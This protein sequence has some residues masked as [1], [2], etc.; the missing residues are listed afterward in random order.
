VPRVAVYQQNRT[1]HFTG[2][3]L[4]GATEQEMFKPS[5]FM[6]SHN[7]QVNFLFLNGRKDFINRFAVANPFYDI[8]T[9]RLFGFDDAVYFFSFFFYKFLLQIK[10]KNFAEYDQ[11]IDIGFIIG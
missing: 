9:I 2:E 4:D 1:G 5:L 8:E 10:L 6:G 11:Y 7:N 3:C